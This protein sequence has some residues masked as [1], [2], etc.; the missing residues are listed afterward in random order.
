MKVGCRT[1]GGE[2]ALHP[3]PGGLG[4]T[5]SRRGLSTSPQV[6][7]RAPPRALKGHSRA[8]SVAR[9]VAE[10]P[11]G[12]CTLLWMNVPPHTSPRCTSRTT[13]FGSVLTVDITLDAGMPPFFMA[14]IS[15]IFCGFLPIYVLIV[16]TSP[17]YNG[18][19]AQ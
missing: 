14:V 7:F 19:I 9:P 17:F 18:N 5:P 16:W 3:T 12:G 1:G 2:I 11:A 13:F 15:A 8:A 6:V 4:E 10:S